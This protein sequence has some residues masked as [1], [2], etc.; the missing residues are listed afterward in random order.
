MTRRQRRPAS[1]PVIAEAAARL[2]CPDC[3][4]D[5]ALTE[6]APLVWALTIVHDDTCPLYRREA[7]S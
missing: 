4:A 5:Q 6:V 3:D 2:G 7:Q 1:P